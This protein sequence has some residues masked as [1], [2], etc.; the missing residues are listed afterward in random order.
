VAREDLKKQWEGLASHWIR[1]SREGPNAN[2]TG[3]LDQPML[4][5]CGDVKGLGVLDCGCGEGRFCRMLAER[6]AKYVLGLDLCKPMIDAALEM[7]TGPDEYRVADVQGLGFIKDE[8]FDLAVSYLNQCDLPDVMAN[9]R[10]VYRVLKPGGKFIIAN[11]HPMRSAT[12]YWHK[13]E[14]GTKLHAKVDN[15]FDENERHWPAFGGTLTNFHRSLSTYVN[16][17]ISAGFNIAGIIEPSVTQEN[18]KKYPDLA[19]ELRVPNFI[20]YVLKRP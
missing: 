10:E 3:L 8:T 19:D 13:A 12:G 2:R 7:K 14:D 6:G 1:E 11:L 4:D 16:G 20:I 18:L 9:T 17:F 15:Y 5:A